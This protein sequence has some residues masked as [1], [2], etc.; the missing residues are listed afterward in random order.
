MSQTPSAAQ[1][2]QTLAAQEQSLLAS[3]GHLL[4]QVETTKIA[5][6]N[7][8]AALQGAELGFQL[9]TPEPAAP[10]ENTPASDTE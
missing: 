6:S 3:L 8:R 4:S 9:A 10:V 1:Q 7:V 5:L 2:H